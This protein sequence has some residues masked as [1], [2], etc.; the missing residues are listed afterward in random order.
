MIYVH[1]N[2][3]TMSLVEDTPIVLRY[4]TTSSIW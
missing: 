2:I 4:S 3:S 1:E